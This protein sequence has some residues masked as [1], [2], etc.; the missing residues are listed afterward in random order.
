MPVKNPVPQVGAPDPE[1]ETSPILEEDEEL[2]LDAELETGF[3]RF[4]GVAYP[5][6]QYVLS[7]NELLHCEERGVW[8]RKGEM[9]PDEPRERK[10]GTR[11]GRRAKRRS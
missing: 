7:G 9:R 3:C 6:G 1:H 4:N 11:A 8:V 5:I 10:M 2:S